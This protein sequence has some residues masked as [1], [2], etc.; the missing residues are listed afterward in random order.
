[1]AV[2]ISGAFFI[3]RILPDNVRLAMAEQGRAS[4]ALPEFYNGRW[5]TNEF[6]FTFDDT[7]ADSS[8]NNNVLNA[9]A[10]NVSNDTWVAASHV[11]DPA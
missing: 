3:N 5:M 8:S 10:A 6:Y 2:D 4:T 7:F 9:F 1:M 11:S